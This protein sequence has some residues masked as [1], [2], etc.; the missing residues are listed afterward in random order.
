MLQLELSPS[1]EQPL[2]CS[3]LTNRGTKALSALPEQFCDNS[4]LTRDQHGPQAGVHCFLTTHFPWESAGSCPR[5]L[6]VLFGTRSWQ[7]LTLTPDLQSQ[8]GSSGLD[9]LD[10]EGQTD[11]SH[12]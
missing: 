8:P 6:H 3:I 11:R 5:V 7:C 9:E 10:V 4:H 2:H 12:L 1:R